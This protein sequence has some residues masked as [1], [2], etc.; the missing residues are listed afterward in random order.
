MVY[1][2]LSP[3]EIYYTQDSISQRWGNNTPHADETIHTTL[4]EL[5]LGIMDTS[6]IPPIRVKQNGS[7]WYSL[8][9]R[10]LYVFKQLGQD[11]ECKVWNGP[12]PKG[13]RY[14][15]CDIRVRAGSSN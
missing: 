1:V 8:D 12:L 13:K 9:N 11:I 15:D 7:C 14:C 5:E 3:D 10:R 2:T 4:F 6:D